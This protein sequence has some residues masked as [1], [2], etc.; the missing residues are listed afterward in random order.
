MHVSGLLT[1]QP[2]G[3]LG[4]AGCGKAYLLGA[5]LAGLFR[6]SA[7][8]LAELLHI[9]LDSRLEGVQLTQNLRGS[10]RVVSSTRLHVDLSI[11][12]RRLRALGELAALRLLCLGR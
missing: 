1:R 7:F 2:A 6:C 12:Q 5:A 4:P 8:R 10:R 3:P 9:V 11:K